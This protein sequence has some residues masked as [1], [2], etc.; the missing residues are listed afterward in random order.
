M[1][2]AISG[3]EIALWDLIGKAS[4]QPVYQLLGGRARDRLPAYAN[5][6]YGGCAHA[7]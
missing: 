1:L 6:W 5:G 4:G 7:G 3:V 2:T